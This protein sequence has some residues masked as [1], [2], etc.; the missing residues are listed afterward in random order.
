MAEV[1]EIDAWLEHLQTCE[2]CQQAQQ[3]R[4]RRGL[5]EVGRATLA[6]RDSAF[7]GLVSGDPDGD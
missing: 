5:C 6:R 1:P 7:R 2:Q 3:R 4:D